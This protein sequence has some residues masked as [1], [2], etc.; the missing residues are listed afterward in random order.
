[1][2]LRFVKERALGELRRTIKDNLPRYRSG[3]FE[4]LAAD[5]SLSFE[6]GIEVDEIALSKLKAAQGH[7][8]F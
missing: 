6:S 2:K 1:M 4:Y 3:E 8:I 5:P 7:R